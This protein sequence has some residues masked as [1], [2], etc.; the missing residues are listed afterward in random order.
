MDTVAGIDGAVPGH[1]CQP[2]GCLRP[3]SC[4]LGPVLVDL[5]RT[6]V[7]GTR[8]TG[9]RLCGEKTPAGEIVFRYEAEVEAFTADAP[10]E[11]KRV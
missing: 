11:Q 2:A 6:Q 4:R 5:T 10:F 1:A 3:R 9:T 7:T 8:V